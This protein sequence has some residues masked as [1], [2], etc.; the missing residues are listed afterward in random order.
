MMWWRHT[1]SFFTLITEIVVKAHRSKQLDNSFWN[2]YNAEYLS[3]S[4][5]CSRMSLCTAHSSVAKITLPPQTLNFSRKAFSAREEMNQVT[6]PA[7][8]TQPTRAMK[9]QAKTDDGWMKQSRCWRSLRLRWLL[10]SPLDVGSEKGASHPVR[11][12]ARRSCFCPSSCC[13]NGT[14]FHS[15]LLS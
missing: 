6:R 7:A 10:I 13:L 2:C 5:L 15:S 3:S 4:P 11:V 14:P 9:P 1:L 12:L 8:V